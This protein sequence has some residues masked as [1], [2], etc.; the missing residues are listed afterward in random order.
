MAPLPAN[1]THRLFIDYVAN[2]REHTAQFRYEGTPVPTSEFLE[3][4][5]DTLITF[6]PLMPN[7][8]SFVAWS[9]VPEGGNFSIPI[10]GSPTTFAGAI[11][12][13]PATAPGFLSF[14]GRSDGGRRCRLYMLGCGIFA[15]SPGTGSS[16]YRISPG[17]NTAVDA[18]RAAVAAL[19]LRAIDGTDV[20]WKPYV[21]VGYNGH[22]QRKVRV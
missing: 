18:A 11:T 22:W 1:N 6:N 14:I 8:W 19:G 3:S 5:D 13:N 21:N 9:Y 2:G 16:D 17:E 15:G 20:N 12:A 4:I 10:A 7:D